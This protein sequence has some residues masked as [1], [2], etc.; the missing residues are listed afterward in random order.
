MQSETIFLTDSIDSYEPISE[1]G[2]HSL[3]SPQFQSAVQETFALGHSPQSA[4]QEL[5][6]SQL[7]QTLF[8][9]QFPQSV[10]QVM[11]VSFPAQDPF[12]Q[13]TAVPVTLLTL[14]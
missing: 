13:L 3:Q 5:Q 10:G 9:Q 7:L 12:P 6:L 1:K 11:Q 4:S 14:I 8:P 2:L